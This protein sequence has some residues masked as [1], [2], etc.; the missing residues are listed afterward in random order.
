MT[1]GCRLLVMKRSLIWAFTS[2]S[3]ATCGWEGSMT[4]RWLLSDEAAGIRCHMPRP[5]SDSKCLTAAALVLG[6]GMTLW[7]VQ[8]LR[9]T[10]LNA[11]DHRDQGKLALGS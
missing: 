10:E 8:S 9:T 6:S 1:T 5:S 4:Q 2:V 11:Q 7:P 3:P